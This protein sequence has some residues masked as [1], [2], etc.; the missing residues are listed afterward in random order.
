MGASINDYILCDSIS[1][2]VTGPRA[3]VQAGAMEYALGSGGAG[4]VG[5]IPLEITL[6][7]T[8][9]VST[10]GGTATVKL[11]SSGL[12]PVGTTTYTD[13][14]TL[15][16]FTIPAGAFT[17]VQKFT[18]TLKDVYLRVNVTAISGGTAPALSGYFRRRQ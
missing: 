10:G 16:T 2:V 8:D 6:F 14:I 1:T 7:L 17:V 13:I 15:P 11:Q 18:L 5:F 4:K 12:G 9:T 3:G